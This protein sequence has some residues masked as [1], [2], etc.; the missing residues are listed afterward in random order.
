M[1]P[2]QIAALLAGPAAFFLVLF[3]ADLNPGHPEV[4]SMAA[5]TL[6]VAIWWLTEATDLAVTAL[7][8]FI[9]MPT[10]GI[11]DSQ[12]VAAQYMDQ[13]I[14]LFIGGVLLAF[15]I[16]RWNLHQRIALSILSKLGANP[17]TMLGAVMV[18][19]FFISM[20]VSNTATVMMM[21]SAVLGIIVQV[22]KHDI[23]VA[24]KNAIAKVMLLGLA[25]SA[26]IGGMSTLVGTATNL[27]FYKIY[28]DAYKDA[29]DMNFFSWFVLAFPVALMLL[30][31]A[32][33]ILKFTFLRHAKNV[34][35]DRSYFVVSLRQLGKMAFEEKV[36]FAVFVITAYLWFSRRDIDFGSFHLKGWGR[37]LGTQASFIT[38]STVA[39]VMAILLFLIP[40]KNEKGKMLLSWE[41]GKKL[42]IGIILLLGSGFAL[43]K[44]CDQSGLS[45]WLAQELLFLKDA[46]P[47]F[48]IAGMCVIICVISELA[49]NVACIQLVL[50]ILIAIQKV[51]GMPPLMLMVPATLAASLGFMLPV[52]TPPNT[53]VFGSGRL[54]VAD[55]RNAGLLLNI[56]GIVIITVASLIIRVFV[57][58]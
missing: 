21:L 20:W 41:E 6:W 24:Q 5:V 2:S 7:L 34:V 18:A 54:R 3:F 46:S 57:W 9:L 25:Y 13:T 17:A 50:P 45:T 35:F 52:A 58:G 28:L 31:A 56:A 30:A 27:A 19:T 29:G 16:E 47:L 10:L 4:T 1:K 51:T 36:V 8:P 15:A 33:F 53:I 39:I 12:T 37:L 14:F 40:S 43:A 55:M 26:S 44:G 23:S 42:P 22:E 49:S 32:F 38:D 11:A 48:V